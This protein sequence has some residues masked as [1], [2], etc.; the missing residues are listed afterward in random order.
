MIFRRNPYVGPGDIF[1]SLFVFL[2]FAGI[3]AVI[4]FYIGYI[5]L[6]IFLSI[7]VAIG[8]GYALYIYIKNF[9][10]ATKSLSSVSSTNLFK[11]TVLKWFTLFKIASRDAFSDNVAVARSA[12]I[13][14]HAYRFLSFRKWM[15]II[16]APATFILGSFLIVA[17]IALQALLLLTAV[18]I[19]IG[20]IFILCVLMFIADIVYS[21][22]ATCKNFSLAFAGKDN[23]FKCFEFSISSNFKA[24]PTSAKN[25]F[26]TLGSYV[27]GIWDENLALGK[28]NIRMG[29]G[30]KLLSF[31][32]YFLLISVVTLILIA[33]VFI[34][35]MSLVLCVSLILIFAFNTIWALIATPIRIIF[36]K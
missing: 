4:F 10:A 9:V 5:G 33:I 30:Y 36:H 12:L 11:T 18:L 6:I 3:F 19:V 35:L 20:I 8:L 13:K 7:G 28:S 24:I 1:A 17:V 34:L 21:I 32:R 22:I 14:S 29:S 27:K 26:I 25:F 15:W 2:V 31:Q 23:I 16:V